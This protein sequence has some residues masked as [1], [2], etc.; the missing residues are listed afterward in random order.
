MTPRE[1][2]TLPQNAMPE[3]ARCPRQP[4]LDPSLTATCT[5]AWT[6]AGATL[7]R[8]HFHKPKSS[9]WENL[10]FLFKFHH[11]PNHFI[12]STSWERKGVKLNLDRQRNTNTEF[13]FGYS[14]TSRLWWNQ[15]ATWP[16]K[17]SSYFLGVM[18]VMR[19]NYNRIGNGDMLALEREVYLLF[20]GTED[21]PKR[22]LETLWDLSLEK[23]NCITIVSVS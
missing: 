16:S 23:A 19:L 9:L 14:T 10:T 2:R 17:F 12:S 11:L 18:E 22:F 20:S 13:N 7:P 15:S 3:R 5:P 1:Y 21:S 8:H 6:W 4:Q